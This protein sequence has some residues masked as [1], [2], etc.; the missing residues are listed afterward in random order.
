LIIQYSGT[1]IVVSH[2]REFLNKVVTSTIVLDGKGKIEE[3][4]GGYDDWVKQHQSKSETVQQQLEHE[5][6]EESQP[7]KQVEPE[8]EKKPAPKKMTLGEKMELEKIPAQ[9]DK[10]EAEQKEI[11]MR[12]ADPMFRHGKI[13]EIAQTKQRLKDIAEELK[14]AY[15]SW[16]ILLQ[17]DKEATKK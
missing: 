7:K 10:L 15:E 4:I 13:E 6:E 17:K 2:D 1:V 9:I 14:K 11:Y 16:E 12:M 8:P 5:E 3:Y